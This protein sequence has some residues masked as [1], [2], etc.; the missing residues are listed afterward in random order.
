MHVDYS[1][2]TG[3]SL[4]CP[5]VIDNPTPSEQ[6]GREHVYPH[7]KNIQEFCISERSM[8][9]NCGMRAGVGLHLPNLVCVPPLSEQT[10]S[11]HVYT[12]EKRTKEPYFSEHSLPVDFGKKTSVSLNVIDNPPV[13]EQ[14]ER[15]HVF[16][17]DKGDTD[18]RRVNI[19]DN[20]GPSE[21]TKVTNSFR[22]PEH[23]RSVHLC[24]RT[25]VDNGCPCKHT[26]ET[27]APRYFEHTNTKPSPTNVVNLSGKKLPHADVSLLNKGL[28][29]IPSLCFN[30]HT[31]HLKNDLDTLANNYIDRY[32]GKISPRPSRILKRTLASITYDLK[33]IG[34]DNVPSNVTR[35]ER[36]ALRRLI[37]DE[38]LVISKADKGDA[39]VVMSTPQYLEMAYKHLSD[40]STYK[41]L[42]DDPTQEIVKRFHQ[43]LDT[44]VS[45]GVITTSQLNRLHLPPQVD[46]QTIYFLPK[47]HKCPIKIRPIVSC[48]NG[49]TYTASAYIDKLLQPH[50]KRVKSYLRNSTDLVRRLQT[51]KVPPNAFLVTLD[52]ESLY[53]NITHEEAI[54]SF[55]KR[56][57]DD[58]NKVFLLDLF[59]Y[60]LKNNIFQFAENVYTQLCGIAM[61]TKLAPALATIYIGDIEEEFIAER[62]KKPDLWVRY[63]DDVFM[64]WSHSREELDSFITD[65]NARRPKIK[66]TA[67]IETQACNFL[68]L[69]IYKS[70]TFVNTGLLSTKIYYKPTNTFAFPL[71]SSYMPNQIHKGIAIGEMMRLL[72][73]TESPTLYKHYQARLIK[74]FERREYPKK[75]LRRIK[76]ITH[77]KRLDILHRCKGK[78]PGERMLPFVTT[79][80]KYR[81]P[82]NSVLRARWSG[83]YDDHKFYSLLPNTPFTVFRNN[84]ALKSLLSAKRRH[85]VSK[86]YLPNLEVGTKEKFTFLRFN[87]PRI[88]NKYT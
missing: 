44:C 29:F 10:G 57:A 63:I 16:P 85:F 73:N 64:T 15:V 6:T 12:R 30:K 20:S 50:M 13:S 81:P 28:S 70:S 46:T 31:V 77:N 9:V 38:D 5:S 19:V 88:V 80:A 76:R 33:H 72:R 4:C 62:T 40:R 87:H 54:V 56:F 39:T 26:R 36:I 14:T 66:F 82:V 24:N 69:T 83:I 75:I 3:L 41:L 67:E 17:C 79:Y 71:G 84:K 22:N 18:P 68:D 2:N 59:K 42:V 8:H 35:A 45:K 34:I 27:E 65:L 43:Y 61:G 25:V 86:K 1:K 53:T 37:K 51:L 32:T 52:I 23:G 58:P 47:I 78:K 55:L 60:V 48:T 74:L 21:H 49:P 7:T 11:V